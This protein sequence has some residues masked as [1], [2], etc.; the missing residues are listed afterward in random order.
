MGAAQKITKT[1]H[2]YIE[3]V[4]G[5]PGAPG[6]WNPAYMLFDYMLIKGFGAAW[7]MRA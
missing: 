4:P 5:V 6:A 7:R 2:F 3:C 1:F